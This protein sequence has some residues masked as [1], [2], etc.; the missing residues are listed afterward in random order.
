[1]TSG[2]AAIGRRR[3]EI[4]LEHVESQGE[5]SGE[6]AETNSRSLRHSCFWQRRARSSTT[7]RRGTGDDIERGPQAWGLLR[8]AWNDPE[9]VTALSNESS[10]PQLEAAASTVEADDAAAEIGCGRTSASVTM[11]DLKLAAGTSPASTGH[12][13]LGGVVRRAVG[14]LA[15]AKRSLGGAMNSGDAAPP[16]ASRGVL[17]SIDLTDPSIFGKGWEVEGGREATAAMIP[18]GTPAHAARPSVTGIGMFVGPNAFDPHAVETKQGLKGCAL[19]IGPRGGGF[20]LIKS[21]VAVWPS[22]AERCK[23]PFTNDEIGRRTVCK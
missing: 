19:M 21:F 13:E 6:L 1:M 2:L 17:E 4:P 5:V 20:P 18:S 8:G 16:L 23:S 9:P 14:P 11:D 7:L 3:S 22:H 12:T 10:E 15:L